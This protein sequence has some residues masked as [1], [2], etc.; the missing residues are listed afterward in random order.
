VE[1]R[2]PRPFVDTNVLFSGLYGPGS[3][4]LILAWHARGELTI[5]VSR[6]VL[7]ELVRTIR[8]KRPAILSPLRTF[9]ANAPPEVTAD[10]GPDEVRA[11][12]QCINARDAPILAAAVK[13]GADCLVSG[14]TRHFTPEAGRRAGIT[15]MTPAEY[16]ASL[17]H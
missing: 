12:E 1:P 14:N 8:R 5:V 4:A 11:A 2:R 13:S 6:Q 15:I 10:P 9:L 7:D 16:L 3:P 17:A